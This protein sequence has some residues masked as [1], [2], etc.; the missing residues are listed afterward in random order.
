MAAEH[1]PYFYELANVGVG[2]ENLAYWTNE[3]VDILDDGD[4]V[5]FTDNFIAED[6][7]D[8][9]NAQ[10][11][12][13]YP[14]TG[15]YVLK[16]YDEAS[17]TAV[18][19]VNPTYIG[20]YTGQKPSIKTVIYKKVNQ[21]TALDE[22]ATGQVD[23]LSKLASGD[24]INAGLDL[25][26]DGGFDYTS[27]PRA[28]YGKVVLSCDFGPTG[29][30]EVRQALTHLLDRNEFARAFTDGHGSVVD[31]PYG[32]SMWFYQESRAE[33]NEKLNQYPYS[34][35]NAVALLEEAGW[36]LDKDG[37]EYK[38]G[39]RY[40]KMDDGTI[41]PLILEWASTVDNAVSELL[42]IQLQEN[43]DVKAAG[44]QINQTLMEFEELLNY[45]Y[46]D[47]SQ[48]PKYGIP[49]FHMFN[50][51]SNFTPV[52]DL[53]DTYTTDPAMLAAGGYNTNFIIDKELEGLAKEMVLKDAEDREGFKK[54]FVDFIERWNYLAPD[55]A[56]YSNIYY[57]VYHEKL[58]DYEINPLV[59]VDKAILY[60]YV[61]E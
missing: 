38:E 32:E 50:L 18:L 11:V 24:E 20:D 27:Y 42:V 54:T 5:Y 4:G 19:E 34:L 40:K 44:M 25:V 61:T 41:A 46:R 10:R 1:L 39:L 13:S 15:A 9:M 51:A 26:D 3:D 55:I 16:D 58:Q 31:G 30:V 47:G 57:D 21:A 33:L 28:G 53:S 48:D 43:P 14:S 7:K 35:D 2:P 59:R 8:H 45:L 23:L 56:L 36:V 49:E 37:N 12:G 29:D 22:L 60:S 6:F 52:Y 17:K